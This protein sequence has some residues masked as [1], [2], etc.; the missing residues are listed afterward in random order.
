MQ[1][2]N[3]LNV[4]VAIESQ[5]A[6]YKIRHETWGWHTDGNKDMNSEE[7]LVNPQ[8]ANN[9]FSVW[10][11]RLDKNRAAKR[12]KQKRLMPLFEFDLT[13]KS[14]VYTQDLD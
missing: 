2:D 4:A 3:E 13:D 9:T 1:I 6:L 7:Q 10:E 12:N 14:R 8:T 11:R 5:P